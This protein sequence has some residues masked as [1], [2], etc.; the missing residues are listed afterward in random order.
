M[1]PRKKRLEARPPRMDS[2]GGY[3]AIIA[4]LGILAL[5]SVICISVSRVAGNEVAMSGNQTVYQRNF[6]LAEGAA[7]EAVDI[8]DNTADI[9]GSDIGWLDRA[10]KSLRVDNVATYWDNAAGEA[11]VP[12]A[13]EIDPAHTLFVAG[14]EGVAPG[15]SLDMEKPRIHAFGIY[16]RCVWNGTAVIKIGYL[17]P[18]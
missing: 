3:L 8:L 10:A 17:A 2:E 14:V 12:R 1:G 16:G 13:S 5:M 6:Y 11:V 9:R 4:A 7:M 18:Y 15:Y